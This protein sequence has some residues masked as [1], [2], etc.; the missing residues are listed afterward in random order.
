MAASYVHSDHDS[1][2]SSEDECM[3]Q[4]GL[5]E[6]FTPARLTARC[7]AFGLEP[8]ENFDIVNGCDLGTIE[9]RGAVQRH[10]DL[11]APKCVVLSP[12]C[13]MFSRLMASNRSRMDPDIYNQRLA[14]GRSLLHFAIAICW[15]QLRRGDYFLLEHPASADSWREPQMLKLMRATGVI[16]STFDQCRFGLKAPFTEL[17]IQKKTRFVHNMP[18]VDQ[19]FGNAMCQCVVPHQHV[20]GSICGVKLSTYCQVY[21]EVLCQAMLH[22]I[23]AEIPL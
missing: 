5:S 21:N 2:D 1:E 13:T 7:R 18:A 22:G 9:G 14:H 8:G 20:E 19:L 12:P 17:P 15:K 3:V 10:L 4:V 23:R 11:H 16:V 6:V